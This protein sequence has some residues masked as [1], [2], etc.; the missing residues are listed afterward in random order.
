MERYCLISPCRDEAAYARRT[1]ESV[2]AQTVRP[3]LWVIVDDGSTDE[4]PVIL[5]EYAERHSFI[6]VIHRHANGPRR[7]GPGVVD[8]FYVGLATIDPGAFPYLCKLDLDLE[9][10]PR[11]FEILLRRM[12]AN[13]S[14][15]TCSGKPYF[16][17][18]NGRLISEACGDEMSVGMAKF[19]RRECFEEIG[20][21][22]REVMWDGIDCHRC[23]MHGWIAC[24]W[25]IPALRF[26]HLRPMGSSHRGILT[27]RMRHGYG[28]YYMGTSLAYMT[29]SALFRMTRPPLI[30]GGLAMWWGY[31]CSMLRR[32]PRY[33][34]SDF[35][36]FLRRYQWQC[37]LHGKEAATQP[38]H[39]R[40]MRH[41]HFRNTSGVRQQQVIW[42]TMNQP[43]SQFSMTDQTTPDVSIVVPLYNEQ[44]NV[45]ELYQELVS[46]VEHDAYRRYEIIFVDDGSSDD[47]L[48]ILQD[49]VGDDSRVTIISFMKNFG[50]TAA[51][52]AGFSYARGRVIVPMDGDRQN[53]P[54][55]IPTLVSKLDEPPGYDIVSGWR[56]NRQDKLLSRRLP[57]I[58]ANRLIRRLTWTREIHDF[59]C[60]MKAYR[61]EV[62][63]DVRLYGEM[64]RFLPAICKWRG[65]R[66]TECV[67]NHRPRVAGSSKYGLKR[68]IK[69]LLDLMTV[70]FL[71]DYL[72]K[73][74][75]FFGKAA[76]LILLLSFA[77][78][79][80]AVL[81]KFNI[82]TEHGSPVSLNNN[83]LVLFAMMTFLMAVM[84]VMIG[85]ISELLVRIYHEAQD[86]KPYKIRW[87]L[88][89]AYRQSPPPD[90]EQVDDLSRVYR[91]AR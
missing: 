58:L 89:G 73:P 26:I 16:I 62:L 7:V 14:I 71:G 66:I 40:A 1:L 19:Y 52:A 68:T 31:V 51:M 59:G 9:L 70:K 85:V 24:S 18:R 75:Y 8:A 55:D 72:T 79:S 21:F 46:V 54:H 27:G 12:R 67:V 91:I 45:V 74:L 49:A 36:A 5:D 20:G 82:W 81:Q 50:Q 28:Q 13:P 76:I 90:G 17:S 43:T 83:V 42:P 65:A 6:R 29:A 69:V 39:H 23:R 86:R 10:P 88:A 32:L 84:F 11:Y 60:S 77:S 22:V 25:D 4:T 38:L 3:A 80:I 63:D 61:R 2:L 78:L 30:I 44:D 53:D 47:T 34:D 64:H 48:A 37:L 35:R 41:R 33:N 15:G 56:R 87:V 57:S